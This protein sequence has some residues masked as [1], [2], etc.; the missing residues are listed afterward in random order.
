MNELEKFYNLEDALQDAIL[1][2]KT[3]FTV[4]NLGE[5]NGLNEKTIGIIGGLTRQ[6][7]MKELPIKDFTTEVELKANID[8]DLA[9]EIA[10]AIEKEV[11]NPVKV[12][13]LRKGEASDRLPKVEKIDV[14]Q[15]TYF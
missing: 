15:K 5:K 1:S 12:L 11:F 3:A 14:F 9:D 7:L 8:A 2:E 4:Y 6:V 10:L 13:L